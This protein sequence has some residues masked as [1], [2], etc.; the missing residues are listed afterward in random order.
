MRIAFLPDG[1]SPNAVYRSIGPM[2]ALAR[3]GHETRMLEPANHHAWGELLRWC[4]VLHVHRVCDGGVVEIA[5]AAKAAGAAVVW[6]DDDDVTKVDKRVAG[7][8]DPRGVKGA[9]RL[10]ARARLFQSVD[11]VTTP[12]AWLAD[13]FRE[14]GA[15]EVR[16]IENYVVDDLLGDRAARVGELTVGWVA[17]SEHRLDAEGLGVAEVLARLLEA[18]PQLHVM[19]VGVDLGLASERYHHVAP[20]PFPQLL[21]KVAA[22]DVGIA[23]LSPAFAI[24]HARSSIKLKEYAAMGVP[25]LASPMGP[26]AGLGE[27]EG[28]RLV[29]DDSWFAELDALVGSARARRRLAKRAVRWGQEQT[30]GRNVERWERALGEVVERG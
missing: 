16:V 29:A 24:N 4:E 8:G 6:D 14:G 11:L 3:R 13:V 19:T 1:T 27:R 15:P 9:R 25:W 23:P 26:Y 5:R 18:H 30:L 2:A 28:G 21:G 17:G 12:S 22:F 7:R 10:T 20:V